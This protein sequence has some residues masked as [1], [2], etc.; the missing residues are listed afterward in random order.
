ML[1]FLVLMN[2][3]FYNLVSSLPAV[4]FFFVVP[5]MDGWMLCRVR[6]ESS[7]GFLLGNRFVESEEKSVGFG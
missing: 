1:L 3:F 5:G 7:R 4:L 6:V 2:F